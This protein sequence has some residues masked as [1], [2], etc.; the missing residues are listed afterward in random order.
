MRA[1]IKSIDE[2][3][4]NT[5]LI[6]WTPPTKK[7]DGGNISFKSEVEWSAEEDKLATGN[8]KAL[9]VILMA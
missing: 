8:W 7:D 5:V 3:A 9:K 6:G 1:F 2:K 4:W